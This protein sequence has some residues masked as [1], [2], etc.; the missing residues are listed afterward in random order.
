MIIR[1]RTSVSYKAS[2]V[3]LAKVVSVIPQAVFGVVVMGT[4]VYW[5]VGLSS[6][7]INFGI[8]MA[9]LQSL[10]ICAQA[11]G[12][13]IGS[14][15]PN[16]HVAL[17]VGPMVTL[18]F[19]VF[20][21]NIVNLSNMPPALS[22][23]AYI[24]PCSYAYKALMQNEFRGLSFQCIPLPPDQPQPPCFQTGEQVLMFFDV[25]GPEIWQCFVY[26]WALTFALHF[27][28]YLGLRLTTRPKVDV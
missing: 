6:N 26:I 20:A 21:G 4:I 13:I 24:S 14:L 19:V 16:I 8:F 25:N 7:L 17:I 2:A 15:V 12:M 11:L 1:E 10:V 5:C 22:W 23:V 28:G 3:Y 27:L 18:M 9:M